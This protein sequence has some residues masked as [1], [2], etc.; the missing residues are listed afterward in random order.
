MNWKHTSTFGTAYFLIIL[1]FFSFRPLSDLYAQGTNSPITD[2]MIKALEK[3]KD[4][5]SIMSLLGA[6][7][8]YGLSDAPDTVQF[9]LAVH[10]FKY[11]GFNDVP[12]NLV[13]AFTWFKKAAEEGDSQSM[14]RLAECYKKGEGTVH[15]NKEALKWY[16]KAVASGFVQSMYAL[17]DCYNY[18]LLGVSKSSVIAYLW[19]HKAEETLCNDE[20]ERFLLNFSLDGNYK[21]INTVDIQSIRFSASSGNADSMLRLGCLL[22]FDLPSSKKDLSESYNWFHKAALAGNSFAMFFLGSCSEKGEGTPQNDDEAVK[23]YKR[24]AQLGNSFSLRKLGGCYYLG[25]FGL[26]QDFKEAFSLFYKC[27]IAGDVAAMKLVGMCYENGDGVPQN[28]VYA[29]AWY[30]LSSGLGNSEARIWQKSIRATLTP[31]MVYEGQQLAT[32][33]KESLGKGFTSPITKD[34]VVSGTGFFI[35]TNGYIITAAHVV[36]KSTSVKILVGTKTTS[37]VVVRKDEKNDIALLKAEG[38]FSALPIIPS[39]LMKLGTDVFTIGFPN[40]SLQGVSPKL[41][42]GVISGLNGIQDDPSCFQIS[43]AVQPGNSGGP[44]LNADGCVLGVINS[45]LN[46]VVAANLTGSLP[47]NVN[48]AVK[49]AYVLPLIDSLAEGSILVKPVKG[50]TFEDIVKLAESSTCIILVTESK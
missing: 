5:S 45:K 35:T 18:G 27:A 24:S 2:L 22:R 21:N 3:E 34:Q 39:S 23:W 9:A 13:S 4:K 11:D 50:K 36:S 15:N 16:N 33:L 38:S 44:L 48:Y 25:R 43:V 20:A 1:C 28:D 42:K 49:S 26:T 12:K 17:A 19:Y 29:Y 37:A 31:A 40:L 41:T 46:D 10:G 47:Q 32:T 14:H 8:Y 6:V 30:S 7:Y